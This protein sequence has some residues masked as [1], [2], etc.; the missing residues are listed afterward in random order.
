MN[1]IL[2]IP[3]PVCAL[4]N[5]EDLSATHR[6]SANSPLCALADSQVQVIRGDS[7]RR[8]TLYESGDTLG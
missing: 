8:F 3:T 7:V 2:N 4:G 6:Y 5:K 1:T